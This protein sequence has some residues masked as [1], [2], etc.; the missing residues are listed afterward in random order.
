METRKRYSPEVKHA[1]NPVKGVKKLCIIIGAPYRVYH[2]DNSEDWNDIKGKSVGTLGCPHPGCTCRYQKPVRLKSTGTRFLRNM[3]DQPC[4]HFQ[5]KTKAGGGASMSVKHQWIQARLQRICEKLGYVAYIEDSKSYSDVLV[6]SSDG[7]AKWSIEVQQRDTDFKKRT[8][9]RESLGLHVL[10]LI[11]VGAKSYKKTSDALFGFPAARLLVLNDAN[12]DVEPWED[13]KLE[14]D[15]YLYVFG[16]VAH[17]ENDT[18]SLK[19]RLTKIET[20]LNE[21]FSGQRRWYNR[22]EAKK[23]GMRHTA[24]IKEDDKQTVEKRLAL[25]KQKQIEEE[26]RQRQ[27]LEAAQQCDT[28]D[29]TQRPN[30]QQREL[31]RQSPLVITSRTEPAPAPTS[32]EPI[33]AHGDNAKQSANQLPRVAAKA[34]PETV[35]SKPKSWLGRQWRKFRKM[36]TRLLR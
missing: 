28:Q 19:T 34:M 12:K 9:Y 6:Q 35:S 13:A 22:D 15:A 8:E 3:D 20:F 27:E 29:T 18:T 10:W 23:L 17:L 32:V 1:P 7:S 21:V 11:T 2:V 31:A 24:W 36:V 5:P 33:A 14:Q 30:E 25:E 26:A 4:D 16:T